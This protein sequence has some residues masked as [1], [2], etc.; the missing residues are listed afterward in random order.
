MQATS[1]LLEI[2]AATNAGGWVHIPIRALAA[3]PEK[4]DNGRE[5][6]AHAHSEEK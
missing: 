2:L 5:E 6:G 4:E 3:R 1:R